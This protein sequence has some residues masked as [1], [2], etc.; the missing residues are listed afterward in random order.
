MQAQSRPDA[1]PT[2][3]VVDDVPYLRELAGIFLARTARVVTAADADEGMRVAWRERPDLILCDDRMPG[4]T[5]ADLCRRVRQDPDLENTPFIMLVSD[6]CAASR[7]AAIRA[8]A[9]DVL[10]KPLSRIALIESVS[11]FLTANRVRGLPRIEMD[12]PVTVT[13][14]D[15]EVSGIVRNVSRGGVFVET[16]EPLHQ[17]DEVGLLFRLPDSPV[18]IAPSAEV[19][20]CRNRFES[21]RTQDGAG[22]R[23]V[24]LDSNSVQTLDDYVYEHTPAPTQGVTR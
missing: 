24:E 1:H 22:L 14:P 4:A 5:G 15:H 6:P 3:L 17:T 10:A 16:E 19:V 21:R 7:G 13:T 20:W 11:R 23:F 18:L 12:V 9:D 8:G 2:V